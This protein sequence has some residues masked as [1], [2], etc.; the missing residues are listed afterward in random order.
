MKYSG[1]L[2]Y[3][4]T[5]FLNCEVESLWYTDSAFPKLAVDVFTEEPVMLL[6]RI[7]A[8]FSSLG[9]Q[10]D[11]TA[12]E[13]PKRACAFFQ[14]A[15]GAY[16][17]ASR[18]LNA[19]K[20]AKHSI[21]LAA[22]HRLK[23]LCLAQAQECFF[24]RSLSA[25]IRPS[26]VSKL[27]YQCSKYYSEAAATAPGPS[28]LVTEEHLK[29]IKVK[30]ELF[31]IIALYYAGQKLKGEGE[32]GFSVAH[33]KW[34]AEKA[35]TL[36]RGLDSSKSHPLIAG[37]VAAL[38][39]ELAEK[40][41]RAFEDNNTIYHETVVSSLPP[42]E[43]FSLAKVTEYPW[44]YNMDVLVDKTLFS[45]LV[46][47]DIT[48]SLSAYSEEKAKLLRQV[49]DD[50]QTA[51]AELERRLADINVSRALESE[52]SF[53]GYFFKKRQ[54]CFAVSTREYA[55]R[56]MAVDNCSLELL[57]I[58]KKLKAVSPKD[59]DAFAVANEQFIRERNGITQAV[60][61][62]LKSNVALRKEFCSVRESIEK[63]CQ[64]SFP[65]N[66][67]SL[68]S[69]ALEA[70]Q[71]VRVQ[72]QGL[73]KRIEK[74]LLHR[75]D[76]EVE[77]RKMIT[78]D[79][80]TTRLS[81]MEANPHVEGHTRKAMQEEIIT[82]E[83]EKYNDI[84]ETARLNL[85]AQQPLLKAVSDAAAAVFMNVGGGALGDLVRRLNVDSEKYIQLIDLLSESESFW[86]EAKLEATRLWDM[87]LLQKAESAKCSP[88]KKRLPPPVPAEPRQYQPAPSF[89]LQKSPP[90]KKS[91]A[92]TLNEGALPIVPF[93]NLEV[94]IPESIGPSSGEDVYSNGAQ[95]RLLTR[96]QRYQRQIP[97][98]GPVS[99]AGPAGPVRSSHQNLLEL[100]E[101][102]ARPSSRT[103]P[104]T[105]RSPG[106]PPLPPKPAG[107]QQPPSHM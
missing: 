69:T 91:E 1:Q 97:E 76:I 78:E 82:S 49:S 95:R 92:L 70:S 58:V 101:V 46:S 68:P 106:A 2:L 17:Y 105:R 62:A 66:L 28:L 40:F 56:L 48:L 94:V 29:L 43:S 100:V 9:V 23:L 42:L 53:S 67:P 26:I 81:E 107:G 89:S 33:L 72:L 21:L 45:G 38:V 57:E 75:S 93:A 60:H 79:D 50:F 36:K 25:G 74:M 83:L 87:C 37:V 84:L 34:A 61:A 11:R 8:I 14:K 90:L 19:S 96:L 102:P 31:Y 80:I 32:Y 7:G 30:E 5:K 24:E 86:S 3:A 55:R 13:G 59:L 54:A 65:E 35:K 16:E 6:F 39:K 20:L 18:L 4:T 22:A 10:V 44:G 12:A 63:L 104:T 47:L 52:L 99:N 85:S 51:S 64:P 73:M 77:L 15:A 27:S 98:E 71:Q 41:E 103:K 88:K